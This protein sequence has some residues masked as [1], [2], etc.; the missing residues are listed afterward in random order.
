MNLKLPFIIIATGL[1]FIPEAAG[2]FNID[3]Q[4]RPRFAFR[5]G[6]RKLATDFSVPTVVISQRTRLSFRYESEK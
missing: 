1:F 2:Q 5:D 4:Y 3:A 6:Y